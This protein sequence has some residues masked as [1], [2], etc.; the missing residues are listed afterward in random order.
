MGFLDKLRGKEQKKDKPNPYDLDLDGVDKEYSALERRDGQ[1]KSSCDWSL[2]GYWFIHNGGRIDEA[3]EYFNKALKI[4]TR[5]QGAWLGRGYCLMSLGIYDKAIACFNE[6]LKLDPDV[7]ADCCFAEAWNK[8]GQCYEA[9]GNEGEA[10]K[11]YFKANELE[12]TK[13]GDT[14]PGLKIPTH[15]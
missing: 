12:Y 11:A 5:Y 2:D 4:D 3:I 1:G 7:V 14:Y 8:K 15:I 10:R 13:E 6:I 9:M